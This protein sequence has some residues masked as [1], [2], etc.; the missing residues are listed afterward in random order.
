MIDASAEGGTQRRVHA[1]SST[2]SPIQDQD[3]AERPQNAGGY[4]LVS[5]DEWFR[6]FDEAGLALVSSARPAQAW[7]K[8]SRDRTPSLNAAAQ[9]NRA[10]ARRSSGCFAAAGRRRDFLIQ[11]KR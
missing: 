7:D 11:M 10:S 1:S 8:L 5:R 6:L 9:S 4:E 2:R 3:R